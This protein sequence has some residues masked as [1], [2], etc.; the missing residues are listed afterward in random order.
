MSAIRKDRF[1]ESDQSFFSESVQCLQSLIDVNLIRP[2]RSKRAPKIEFKE[3][4][5]DP[6]VRVERLIDEAWDGSEQESKTGE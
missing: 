2:L 5:P 3:L 4:Y 1:E 6:R